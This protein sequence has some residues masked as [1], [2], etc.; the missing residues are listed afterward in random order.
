MMRG[1]VKIRSNIKNKYGG[2]TVSD[3]SREILTS[4]MQ[5]RI[6]TLLRHD[7]VKLI[8]IELIIKVLTQLVIAHLLPK[9]LTSVGLLSL[10]FVVPPT[11]SPLVSLSE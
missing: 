2:Y 8:P 5:Q 4:S 7:Q 10:L 11:S 1:E 9:L 3:K 6:P